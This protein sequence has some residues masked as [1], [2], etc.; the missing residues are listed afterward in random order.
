[1]LKPMKPHSF[2]S[3]SKRKANQRP[4]TSKSLENTDRLQTK[5]LPKDHH[6]PGCPA[7]CNCAS[8]IIKRWHYA[9]N[10][11]IDTK[12]PIKVQKPSHLPADASGSSQRAI[13]REERFTTLIGTPPV[14]PGGP[15]I[16]RSQS[17]ATDFELLKPQ[18]DWRG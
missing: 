9:M 5:P 1:M 13:K 18:V 17:W 16:Q 3:K 2:I 11:D 12:T 14:G 4:L 8:N 7:P 10:I 15:S 6:N